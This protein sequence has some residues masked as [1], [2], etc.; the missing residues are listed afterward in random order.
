MHPDGSK[1][2][3]PKTT[4]G[5]ECWI[6]KAAGKVFAGPRSVGHCCTIQFF[7]DMQE[8]GQQMALIFS[9]LSSVQPEKGLNRWIL[10]IPLM[11][12]VQFWT[13][14]TTST[15][16]LLESICVLPSWRWRGDWVGMPKTAVHFAP[17][18]FWPGCD[19]SSRFSFMQDEVAARR[20][21]LAEIQARRRA[22]AEER[23]LSGLSTVLCHPYGTWLGGFAF[24]PTFSTLRA[25]NTAVCNLESGTHR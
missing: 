10:Q 11:G 24:D 7:R 9:G 22:S 13:F 12:H 6:P 23:G 15:L 20:K 2:I 8:T 1:R 19:Q 21:E 17:P 4:T 16:Q 5:F 14:W 18:L 3:H 25:E